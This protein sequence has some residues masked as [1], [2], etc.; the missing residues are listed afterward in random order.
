MSMKTSCDVSSLCRKLSAG[1]LRW[2]G[3]RCVGLGLGLKLHLD[4]IATVFQGSNTLRSC[5]VVS[6]TCY[7]AA[8]ENRI[9]A[10]FISQQSTSHLVSHLWLTTHMLHMFHLTFKLCIFW[11]NHSQRLALINKNRKPRDRFILISLLQVMTYCFAVKQKPKT[12]QNQ[13]STHKP[14]ARR[15]SHHESWQVSAH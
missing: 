4:L 7:V 2:A 5:F 1:L 8:V 12:K 14:F 3:I 9:H 15:S 11:Y 13:K 10:G 6:Y